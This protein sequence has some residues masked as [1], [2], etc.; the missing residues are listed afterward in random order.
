MAR[1][2]PQEKTGS[3][4]PRRAFVYRDSRNNANSPGRL[5]HVY[6]PRHVAELGHVIVTLV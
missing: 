3:L 1:S 2:V 5:S 4:T 6:L